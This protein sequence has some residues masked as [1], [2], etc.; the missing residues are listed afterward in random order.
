MMVAKPKCVIFDCEGTLVDSEPLYCRALVRVFNLFGASLSYQ[1][2]V[3]AFNGG[4]LADV[5]TDIAALTP[6]EIDIEIVE[7]IYRRE[8]DKLFVENL[9]AMP[10]AIELLDWLDDNRIDYC[11]ASNAP[12]E[13][14][15]RALQLAGLDKYFSTNI[16]SAFDTNS[17]K[18]EP[19]L[20]R[21]SAMNM[22][23]ALSECIYIDDTVKGVLAGLRANVASYQLIR[24]EI[25][26][27]PLNN[28][29]VLDAKVVESLGQLHEIL[30]N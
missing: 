17:W 23:Y 2:V 16:Y 13:K 19:D 22:G 1:D 28:N 12:Y 10:G 27:K 14:I 29:E 20:V 6:K 18:P 26:N 9:T 24:P 11:V 15:A 30:A 5:L 3:N 21:Y 25:N 8:L 4:K 7:P